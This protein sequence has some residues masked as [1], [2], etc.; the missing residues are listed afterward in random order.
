MYSGR[1]KE[2][3]MLCGIIRPAS[4]CGTET[5]PDLRLKMTPSRR[6]STWAHPTPLD[7]TWQRHVDLSQLQTTWDC[8]Q[9]LW[10]TCMNAVPRLFMRCF[11]PSA[12]VILLLSFLE[13]SS[14]R[15]LSLKSVCYVTVFDAIQLC[16]RPMA[17][18]ASLSSVCRSVCNECRP[19]VA[20][21][22]C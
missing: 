15:Q 5:W 11:I 13:K 2:R 9:K 10:W 1:Q 3:T 21:S 14:Y 8:S 17:S 12:D 6:R 22:A 16:C 4:R 19:I 20:Y 18:L 7:L